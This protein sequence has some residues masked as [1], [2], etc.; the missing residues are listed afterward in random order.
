LRIVNLWECFRLLNL[1]SIS[2]INR[3]AEFFYSLRNWWKTVLLSEIIVAVI[4]VLDCWDVMWSVVSDG[5]N[6]SQIGS[7]TILQRDSA[8]TTA[9]FADN[10]I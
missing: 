2:F 10:V 4:H 1:S 7:Q 6:W 5:L 3:K 9:I 8:F